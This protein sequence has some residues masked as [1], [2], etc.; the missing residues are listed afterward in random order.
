MCALYALCLPHETFLPP[1]S[2]V[3]TYFGDNNR[4][5]RCF[6]IGQTEM[7]LV[8]HELKLLL[9]SA[10]AI[11]HFLKRFQ[12]D[13]GWRSPQKNRMWTCEIG[14]VSRGQHLSTNTCDVR[15]PT[16]Q[17]SFVSRC[18]LGC[19]LY[20]SWALWVR[21]NKT[22]GHSWLNIYSTLTRMSAWTFSTD[23]IH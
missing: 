11:G 7:L 3:Q 4:R 12:C 22:H 15:L 13:Q 1:L 6:F 20:V 2:L 14:M 21:R 9:T 18:A 5:R 10:G 17:K 23:V 8:H 19:L 16:V